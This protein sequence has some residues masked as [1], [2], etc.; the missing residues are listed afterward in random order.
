VIDHLTLR[1]RDIAASK[2]FYALALAPLGY[3]LAMEY[4]EGA[5]FAEGGKPDFWLTADP[6]AKPQ[7]LAFCAESRELV[8]AFFHAAM[9]AGGKDNGPPGLRPHYHENYYGAFVLDPTGHNIEAVCHTPVGAILATRKA[10]ARKKAGKKA[11]AAKKAPRKAA[12]KPAR[13]AR[14]KAGKKRGR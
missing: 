4:G 5:G 12:K 1:V 6:E 11:K 8:D 2:A 10:P 3:E 13:A 7:H 14:G 9:A